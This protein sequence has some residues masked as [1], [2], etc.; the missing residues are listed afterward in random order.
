MKVVTA[1][2]ALDSG[3]FTPGSVLDGASNKRIGGVPLQNFGNQDYGPT[4]LTEALTN[5]VNTVWAQVAQQLGKEEYY[6]YMER[7]GFNVE[8]PMDYP[9]DQLTPSGVYGRRGRLLDEDDPVDIGRVAIGQERLQV[10]PLQMATVAAT[11][12]NEGSRM[13]P[14]LGERVV[15]RDG[16]LE[17]RVRTAEAAQVMSRD[18]A[19]QLKAMMAQVVKEGSGTQ[20]A[21]EGVP[22]AGKTGTAEVEGGATNQAWFIGFAPSTTRRWRWP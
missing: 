6:D 7:F 5:S 10:T 17:E 21:L 16:R 14:R 8:P 2:A 11:V 22:V 1:A 9:P 3:R 4:S 13:E 18:S 20:A 19:N 12:A 15:A